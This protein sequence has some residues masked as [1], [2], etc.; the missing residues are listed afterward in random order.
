MIK[1]IIFDCFGVLYV[2]HGPEYIKNHAQNYERI[3]ADIKDLSNQADYGL[4]SQDEWEKQVADLAGLTYGE[5]N[6]HATRG[7]GRNNELMDYIEQT[8]RSQYKIGLLSNISRGTMERFFTKKERE[9]LFDTAVLSSETGMIKPSPSAFVYTCEQLGVDVSEAIMIDD[10][11]DNVRG[12]SLAGLAAIEYDG[13]AHLKR[14]I[15]K[16]LPKIQ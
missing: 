15:E 8:L 9:Q 2:H 3:R 1:A 16:L 13:L 11:T 4:I 10:N 5:V 7:F 14:A 12:A 6:R